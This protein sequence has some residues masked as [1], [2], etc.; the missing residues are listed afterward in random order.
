METALDENEFAKPRFALQIFSVFAVIGLALVSVGVYSVVSYSVS[1]Q[2]R[3]IGI[4]LALGATRNSVLGLVMFSGMRLILA[5]VGIGL[6]AAFVILRVLKNQISGISVYDPMTLLGVVGLLALV[7][8]GAC[9]VPSLR[10][11]RIDPLISL[12]Y[13]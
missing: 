11:T 2:N 3:E 5:G 1:Q 12:R 8:S 7:G 4:R 10:A 6:L 9:F 13:E